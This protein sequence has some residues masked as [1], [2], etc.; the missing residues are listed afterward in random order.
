[1]P[2][3]PGLDRKIPLLPGSLTQVKART[4][5]TWHNGAMTT[6][7]DKAAKHRTDRQ[8]ITRFIAIYCGRH[9]PSGDDGLCDDC[10]ELLDYALGRLQ[11]CPM[12][13][14]PKCKDCPVHCYDPE[15]RRR[16]REVMKFSG[17]YMVKRGRV[18]WLV[19]YFLS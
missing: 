14:K 12:D 10:T 17:I 15:H 2:T 7:P 8:I 19:K 9:H 4:V 3:S 18:D 6:E 5:S 13:P 11:R 1:M 16:I